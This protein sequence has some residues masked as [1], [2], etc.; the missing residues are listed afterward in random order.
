MMHKKRE[1]IYVHSNRSYKKDSL[2]RQKD[3]EKEIWVII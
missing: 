3:M 2:L 1:Y